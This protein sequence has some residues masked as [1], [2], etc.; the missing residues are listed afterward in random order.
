MWP[1]PAST[2]GRLGRTL[3]LF[4]VALAPATGLRGGEPAREVTG[5]FR[6]GPVD[7]RVVRF[8]P[9]G[10]GRRP[11]VVLLHGADGWGQMPGYR[12]AASGLTDAGCVAV[13]VRYYDRT[14]TADGVRPDDRAD[15]TRWLKG[16]AQGEAAARSRK[17]FADWSE[18]V[19]DAVAYTRKLPAVD[20]DRV[21][22]VGF[23]LGGYLALSTAPTCDPPVRAVVELFGGLPEE[24]R[25]GP[26]KFPP[27]LILHGDEDAVVPVTEAYKAAGVVLAQK[28]DVEID[29]R[30]GVGHVFIRPRTG[31]PDRTELDRGRTRMVEFL[32]RR[33]ES[34]TATAR[35]ADGK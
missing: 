1:Q 13:L 16:E 15:F 14:L 33:F 18:T 31:L 20:P 30:P 23:S 34:G 9:P 24:S 7:V 12:F 22:I 26:G 4:V 11:A 25:K 10:A 6:S 5:S 32:T 8:E 27:T 29:V 28:Q 21:A 17:H 2:V 19:R 35:K 3:A